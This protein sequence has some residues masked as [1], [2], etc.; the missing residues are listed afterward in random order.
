LDREEDARWQYADG[1]RAVANFI[2]ATPGAP[3]PPAQFVQHYS[4]ADEFDVATAAIDV[5]ARPASWARGYEIA[6]REFG[7]ITYGAQMEGAT[8]KAQQIRRREEAIAAR[9][10][11]LGL[12]D[13]D[14]GAAA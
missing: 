3:L 12:S 1:L 7:R 2:E 4:D 14:L 8:R 9:E 13:D 11:E 10:R 6:T 5:T